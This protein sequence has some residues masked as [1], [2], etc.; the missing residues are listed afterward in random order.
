MTKHHTKPA[1]YGIKRP[2]RKRQGFHVRRN[3]IQVTN[4]FCHGARGQ[5]ATHAW[6]NI[7]GNNPARQRWYSPVGTVP[8]AF[9]SARTSGTIV[10]T[11]GCIPGQHLRNRKCRF[12]NPR[13]QIKH[14]QIPARGCRSKGWK[15]KGI[16]Q[17]T[18]NFSGLRSKTVRP[19]KPVS[20]KVLPDIRRVIFGH[21]FFLPCKFC[22][23]TDATIIKQITNPFGLT[24]PAHDFQE[25]V[26]YHR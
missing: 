3:D 19:V 26:F 4:A 8:L 22:F 20:R 1:R 18:I 25:I 11:A 16:N 15:V 9:I 17:I 24:I 21:T 23:L 6:H 13:C 12:P 7:R 5:P 10:T 2:S 14:L